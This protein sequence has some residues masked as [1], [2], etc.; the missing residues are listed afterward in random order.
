MARYIYTA[1]VKKD[2]ETVLEVKFN[3]QS[4]AEFIMNMLYPLIPKDQ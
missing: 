1:T 2:N 4:V 3:D